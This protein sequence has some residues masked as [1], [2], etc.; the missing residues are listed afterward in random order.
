MQRI[1]KCMLFLCS[2]KFK[3]NVFYKLRAQFQLENRFLITHLDTLVRDLREET[4]RLIKSTYVGNSNFKKVS[5]LKASTK[6]KGLSVIQGI[7]YND[8]GT[9]STFGQRMKNSRLFRIGG[10]AVPLLAQFASIGFGIW[11]IV[12]GTSSMTKDGISSR[13]LLKARELDHRMASL[14]SD[15]YNIV[16][17]LFIVFIKVFYLHFLY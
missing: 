9:L 5:I 13:I 8:T 17:K 2:D 14:N 7:K 4:S 6:N 15:Y 12:D 11:E 10:N 16:G 3:Q 1:E